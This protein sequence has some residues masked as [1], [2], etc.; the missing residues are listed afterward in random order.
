MPE[1]VPG[2]SDGNILE[3]VAEKPADAPTS[4]TENAPAEGLATQHI[5]AYDPNVYIY[6]PVIR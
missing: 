6:A 5:P 1:C 3:C 2:S 4:A